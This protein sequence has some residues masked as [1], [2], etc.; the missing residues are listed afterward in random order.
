MGRWVIGFLALAAAHGSGGSSGCAHTG[1][2]A[3]GG[4]VSSPA[5]SPTA[6]SGHAVS[7]MSSAGGGHLSSPASSPMAGSG[8][9]VSSVAPPT[10]SSAHSISPVGAQWNAGPTASSN[11]SASSTAALPHLTLQPETTGSPGWVSDFADVAAD[12]ASSLFQSLP[13][14]LA[15]PALEDTAIP[16]P[17]LPGDVPLACHSFADCGEGVLHQGVLCDRSA[18]GGDLNAAGICRD[19]C[20]DDD[21]CPRP[22]RCIFNLDPADA[23]WG[24]CR[25]D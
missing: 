8:H 25:K 16:P 14:L 4:H 6:G 15:P 18:S 9:T 1:A 12:I 11:L 23:T 19:A 17:Q 20:R 10:A 22:F 5:W 24:G 2:S 13:D 21:D 7:S 3:G